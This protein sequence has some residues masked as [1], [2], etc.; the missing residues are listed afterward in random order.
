MN[1]ALSNKYENC[2]DMSRDPVAPAIRLMD[3]KIQRA[4]S[5]ILNASTNIKFVISYKILNWS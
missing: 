5:S 3:L 2:P 1:D 4:A